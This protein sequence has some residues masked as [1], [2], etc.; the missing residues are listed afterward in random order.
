MN[1]NKYTLGVIGAG[2]M[3]YAIVCGILKSGILRA[4]DVIISD[5]NT[6]RLDLF[7][8]KGITT[9]SDNT[10]LAASCNNLLF[11]IKPQI[12]NTV[13][14][15]IKSVIDADTVISIMAGVSLATLK[16]AL[17]LR[18]Y[19]R[20]MPNTPALVGNGMSAVAFDGDF[21]S[22]FVLDVFRSIGKVVEL[23]ETLFDAVTS[24]S[25]SGPA[26]V[27]T[28]IKALI[29]GGV[30]GGLDYD[31]AKTLALQTVTGSVKMI[32]NS[33]KPITELID[34]VCSK[35]GTTIQAV[36]SF[37]EDGLEDAVKRG[38]EKCRLRSIELSNG[39][40]D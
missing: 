34:A 20:I 2:N 26:Y 5:V 4:E 17:G 3:A 38:M 16:N 10:L 28:F 32:E 6:D 24:L 40:K 18:N 21:R 1:N 30:N 13:F 31:T 22:D 35:G 9:T 12:S 15:E 25:G 29:D 36:N 8:S 7:K 27:Y 11:A 23:D 39:N 19:A 33:D 37:K 14:E